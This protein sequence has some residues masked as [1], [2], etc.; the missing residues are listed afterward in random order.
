MFG[1]AKTQMVSPEKASATRLVAAAASLAALTMSGFG[2]TNLVRTL[3]SFIG[4][5]GLIM[6]GGLLYQKWRKKALIPIP[7]MRP[8]KL[9]HEGDFR[10]N[11][12]RKND[13]KND[14]Q[15]E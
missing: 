8:K 11:D 15:M 12:G 9:G 1:F 2:F 7:A 3:F 4:Y 6:L 10:N 13:Q 14:G 5:A